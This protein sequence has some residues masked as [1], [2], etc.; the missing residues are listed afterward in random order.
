M[1]ESVPVT[2][3]LPVPLPMTEAPPAAE[4]FSVPCCTDRVVISLPPLASTSVTPSPVITT[5]PVAAALS[6]PPEG[7]VH[8]RVVHAHDMHGRVRHVAV[9]A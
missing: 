4:T 3:T 6:R 8:R 5:L 2:V 9:G 1:A 7:W